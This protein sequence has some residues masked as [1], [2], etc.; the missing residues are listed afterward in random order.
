MFACSIFPLTSVEC[1]LQP[2]EVNALIYS[3]IKGPDVC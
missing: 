2:S 3:E 1:N